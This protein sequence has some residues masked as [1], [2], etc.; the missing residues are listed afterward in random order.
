MGRKRFEA[1]LLR[2]KK[3]ILHL[4]ENFGPDSSVISAL[5]GLHLTPVLCFW[6]SIANV[7]AEPGAGACPEPLGMRAGDPGKHDSVGTR[8]QAGLWPWPSTPSIPFPQEI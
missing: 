8:V 4:K 5:T 2:G 7:A 6:L 1:K 3:T